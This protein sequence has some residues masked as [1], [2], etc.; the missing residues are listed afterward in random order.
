MAQ[1]VIEY[2]G[3]GLGGNHNLIAVIDTDTDIDT[4]WTNITTT[5]QWTDGTLV[6]YAQRW[7]T[8]IID[9]VNGVDIFRAGG[10]AEPSA[11]HGAQPSDTLQLVGNTTSIDLANGT[12]NNLSI[13]D[14][15]VVNITGLT[16]SATITGIA[17]GVDGARLSLIN[18]TGQD[19]T[20]AHASGSSDAENRILTATGANVSIVGSGSFELIYVGALERWFLVSSEAAGSGSG[21][22]TSVSVTTAAGVSGSV[23]TATTT[24]AITI[25]LGAITPTSVVA[26]G[27]VKGDT[28]AI[29]DS[30]DSHKLTIATNSNLTANRTLRVIPG[31]ADRDVTL[32]GNLT[33]SSNAVVA[34]T[35]IPYE[36]PAGAIDGANVTFTFA[37]SPLSQNHLILFLNGLRQ[38]PGADF[39]VA[40]AVATFAV[41]PLG[42]D[43]VF[44]SYHH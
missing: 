22:V 23:A 1:K 17:G 42:G 29:N 26:T 25:T 20:I 18:N 21:T 10:A 15:N 43:E 16:G 7:D 33:V 39:T 44:A 36:V 13:G 14:F 28:L 3:P 32:S 12:T 4:E 6:Q 24:P 27:E 30:D 8:P 2:Y 19:M 34:G 38:T 31:D 40:G 35:Y 41:A 9:T 37:N 11:T 5:G